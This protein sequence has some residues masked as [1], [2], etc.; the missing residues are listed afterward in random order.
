MIYFPQTKGYVSQEFAVAPAATIT[1]EGQ[2]LVNSLVGGIFGVKPS[3]GASGESFVG[4][5]VSQQITIGSVSRVEEYVVPVSNVVTL[6]RTPSSGTV[7]V[8]DKTAGAVV[9][10]SGGGAW[11]LTGTTLTLTSTQTGHEIAV[12]FKYVA[13]ANEARLLQGDVYPGGAAGNVVGQVGVIKN[14]TIFTSEFDTTVD[15]NQTNPAVTLGAN[16]QL[17]IGGSG[18]VVQCSIVSVPSATSPF[19]GVNLRG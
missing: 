15:W 4:L 6:S 3:T 7:S 10:A 1:A 14:G 2:A 12:Y 16:G 19:L 9:P 17:T 11:S 8:Y 18:T 5:A 13:S